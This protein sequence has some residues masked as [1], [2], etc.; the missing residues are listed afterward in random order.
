MLVSNITVHPN[1]TGTCAWT[2][3]AQSEVW[4]GEGYDPGLVADMS[5]GLAETYGIYMVLSFFHQYTLL[6]PLTFLKPCTINVYCNNSG[7]IE[8]LQSHP[9][10]PYPRDTICNDYPIFA[11]IQAQIHVMHTMT[12]LFHHVKH[13]QKERADCKLMLLAGKT[14][15]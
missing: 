11:E 9:S 6:H 4:S 14:Q 8:R 2:I 3:W 1:G 12:V 7:I 13:H 5:S 15:H 10:C